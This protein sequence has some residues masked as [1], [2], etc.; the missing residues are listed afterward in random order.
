MYKCIDSNIKGL[1]FFHDY[2]VLKD[3]YKETIDQIQNI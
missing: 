3:S 2:F 1:V